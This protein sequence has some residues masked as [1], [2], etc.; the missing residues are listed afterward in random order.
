[1]IVDRLFASDGNLE[2]Q[3]QMVDKWSVSDDRKVY[4]FTLRDGLKFHDG[5]PVTTRDVIASM[6][7]WGARDGAGKILMG[8]TED[9][10]AKDDKTFEWRLKEPYGLV[11]DTLAKTGTIIPAIMREKEAL[12][13]PFQQVQEMVGSGPFTFKLDEWVPGSKTV[14]ASFADY[15]PLK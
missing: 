13:D 6:K 10:V 9:L 2:P 1:M 14:Y 3:P 11:I 12:T 15:A 8:Y 7:R 4:S 5:T